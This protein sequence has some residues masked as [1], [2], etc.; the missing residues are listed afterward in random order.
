MTKM[1]H[2]TNKITP[3]FIGFYSPP[4][5]TNVF[6]FKYNA[7]EFLVTFFLVALGIASLFRWYKTKSVWWLLTSLSL[8]L[9]G[10]VILTLVSS[11][12]FNDALI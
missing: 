4:R 8:F 3:L 12:I 1:K 5:I 10:G 7:A 9:V 6:P 2:L 11:I